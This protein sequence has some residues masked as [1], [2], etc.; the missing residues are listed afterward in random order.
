MMT[1]PGDMPRR[2]P[3]VEPLTWTLY[4]QRVGAALDAAAMDA[5]WES[6]MEQRSR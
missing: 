1:R 4:L 6:Y 3:G 5:S 2:A